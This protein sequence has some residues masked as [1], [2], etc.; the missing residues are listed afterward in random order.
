MNKLRVNPTR[1]IQAMLGIVIIMAFAPFARPDEAQGKAAMVKAAFIL[2]FVKLT[3]W[4]DKAFA[5]SASPLVVVIV[6]GDVTDTSIDDVV[7]G[8]RIHEREISLRRLLP[9]PRERYRDAD[10]YKQAWNIAIDTLRKSHIVIFSA[11]ACSQTDVAIA[12]MNSR[13]TLTIGDGPDF[14]KTDTMI[15]LVEEDGR[16]V[17]YANSKSIQRSDLT[18]SSR[19]L[20][21]ARTVKH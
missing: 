10:D 12:R 1:R 9:P 3:A 14:P 20:R 7:N 21:L 19:L 16:I 13:A 6:G 18:L 17:F 4:P 11:D 8:L 15:A 2:N 5:D